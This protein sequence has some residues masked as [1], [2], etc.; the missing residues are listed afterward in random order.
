MSIAVSLITIFGKPIADKLI[1]TLGNRKD[2]AQKI[3]AAQRRVRLQIG[4]MRY[5]ARKWP[6]EGQKTT[7]FRGITREILLF[8][9]FPT[10]SPFGQR[11]FRA[12][13]A[14]NYHN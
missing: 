6:V 8:E 7:R 5:Q 4:R 1:N 14:G 10:A 12:S 9:N 11:L 2:G 3:E 13:L